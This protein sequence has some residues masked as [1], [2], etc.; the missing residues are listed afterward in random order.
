MKI[1]AVIATILSAGFTTSHAGAQTVSNPY[2]YTCSAY[3][4]AQQS[5]NR[6]E[7]NA[8]LFW[9][10][11]YLQA[12]LGTLPSASFSAESFDKDLRDVH[13]TLLKICPNVPDMPIATF[14]DNLAGDFE[15]TGKP[16]N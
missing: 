15:K 1:L 2:T 7:A 16:S 13:A 4:A 10:L 12:R 5:E 14:M 9:A 11:G 3:L 8:V 6:G